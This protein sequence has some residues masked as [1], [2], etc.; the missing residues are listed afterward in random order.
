MVYGNKNKAFSIDFLFYFS[1]FCLKQKKYKIMYYQKKSIT[2]ELF[3]S[4]EQKEFEK[5]IVNF[6]TGL[7]QI[8]PVEKIEEDEGETFLLLGVLIPKKYKSFVKKGKGLYPD[9]ERQ[10]CIYFKIQSKNKFAFEN[11]VYKF[12]GA[13]ICKPF[14]AKKHC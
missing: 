2:Y 8:I 12:F 4:K 3:F 1:I 5:H 13:Y 10:H 7:D 11:Y 14:I 6:L 9:Y